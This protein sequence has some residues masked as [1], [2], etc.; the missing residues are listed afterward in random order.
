MRFLFLLYF[1]RV[2]WAEKHLET[3][4]L[5]ILTGI[6]AMNEH[7]FFSFTK[8]LTILLC[9][10]ILIATASFANGYKHE[11]DSVRRV[12]NACKTEAEKVEVLLKTFR[13]YKDND[14]AR[15]SFYSNWMYE[16]FKHSGDTHLLRTIY[17]SRG[18]S[19]LNTEKYDSAIAFYSK[20]LAYSNELG[21]AQ[22]YYRLGKANDRLGHQILALSQ[23]KTANAFFTNVKSYKNIHGTY[24]LMI[25]IYARNGDY[26]SAVH[27]IKKKMDLDQNRNSAI[28]EMEDHIALAS[29]YGQQNRF[30][31]SSEHLSKAL[32]IAERSNYGFADIYLSIGDLFFQK[33]NAKMAILY[34]NKALEKFN[35]RKPDDVLADIYNSLG[36]VYLEAGNDREAL[37]Y[38]SKGLSIAKANGFRH[39]LA[40]AY[41]LMGQYFK[42]NRQYNLAMSNLQLC[43]NTGCN[44]CSRLA[45]FDVMVEIG[46]LYLSQGNEERASEWYIESLMLADRFNAKRE[47]SVAKRKMGSLFFTQQKYRQAE[48]SFIQ[49]MS[50]AQ[51]S[52]QPSTIKDIADT[53]SAFYLKQMD[54][55]R[56][57]HYLQLS[58]VLADSISRMEGNAN[59]AALEMNFEFESLKKA[60]EAKQALSL[61]EIK[62]Q[63][64]F[65]NFL[66]IIMSLL[67]ILGGI[68]LYNY[69]KKMLDNKLLVEQKK[70]IEENNKAIIEQVEE[71]KLQKD[72]IERISAKLHEADLLKLHFF[73]NISH[74]LRTP[75]TL[76]LHPLKTLLASY[77]FEKDQKQQ[78]EL[79]YRNTLRLHELTNQILDLQKLDSGSLSLNLCKDDIVVHLKGVISSFEGFCSVTNCRLSFYSQHTAVLCS[80]DQDKISK[81]VGNLISNAFK[82]NKDG[83]AVAFRLSFLEAQVLIIVQDNGIGIPQSNLNE[84]F[85]RYYQ[86]EES[87]TQYEGTGIGLAYV[88]EL[89]E[90]MKG[91]IELFSEVGSGTKVVVT[92]PVSDIQV[93]Q[94]DP[95]CSEQ[96]PPK[97]SLHKEHVL[98]QIE[99][100]DDDAPTILIVEDN[101]DLRN[102]IGR[103]FMN[104]YHLIYAQNGKEGIERALQDLP[105]VII[106]DVMMPQMNGLDMS[107]FLKKNEQTCHIPIVL[108][109]AKDSYENH[110]LGYQSGADDYLVKPFDSVVLNLKIQNIIETREAM[111][112]QFNIDRL[113]EKKTSPYN[114]MD[115][116]FLKKCVSLI[117]ENLENPDF[118]VDSL[119]EKTSFGR[120]SLFRKMKALTNLSPYEFI[121]TYKL[122][123]AATLLQSG[124]RVS[125]V[126]YSVGFT[127]A[128]SFS[129]AFKKY[130]GVVPSEYI[131]SQK[132]VL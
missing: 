9:F 119:L 101:M 105:D 46:D 31:L 66:F 15:A 88:K 55:K 115:Q 5:S 97:N 90:L 83:G 85:T 53:L 38:I 95:V 77:R 110:V 131:G 99:K 68:S 81:I 120:R 2:N 45:F 28:K 42:Q 113:F 3:W 62:R 114:Q 29:L 30:N 71:I 47:R 107:R 93:L 25:A 106:S 123:H 6:C 111:K 76:I 16:G 122:K 24:D 7:P 82:Y 26:D 21:K 79:I 60:D 22:C 57:Y 64:Q 50:D 70:R 73:S 112:K 86:M 35:L 132:P 80:F 124:Q 67:I 102:M 69:R 49:S 94:P 100:A 48:H 23:L 126:A 37:L 104:S 56:A 11:S 116:E 58:K 39:E 127:S 78:L 14:F 91:K 27:Y 33:K 52:K 61:E 87:N 34:Y 108:L 41:R 118:S 59:V 13:K 103:I 36:K 63:K 75:L 32:A 12:V 98:S 117:K 18:E 89:T 43:Y 72:E 19:F 44:S 20:A 8:R 92:L 125:E 130:Y 54:F 4:F 40:N 109:T 96:I 84:V 51:E 65:R 128:Q 17:F 129:V 74:E 1:C 121:T 10:L